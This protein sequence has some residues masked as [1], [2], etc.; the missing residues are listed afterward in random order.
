MIDI[1]KLQE[2][3]CNFTVLFV[4]DDATL[5]SKTIP[6]FERFFKKVDAASDGQKGLDAYL[7]HKDETNSYYDIVISDIQMPRMDGI[8]LSKKILKINSRQKIII[9]SAHN[10]TKYMVELINI[11]IS[12][13][14]QKPIDNQNMFQVM[15]DVS[16]SLLGESTIQ[17]DPV[18][19]FDFIRKALCKEEKIIDLSIQ[20]EKLL[21]L[22]CKN[23]NQSFKPVDIFNHIYYDQAEK[24]FSNDSV[25]SLIKRLRKKLPENLI[26][27]TPGSGYSIRVL[28]KSF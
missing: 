12:G 28:T 11:G 9:T 17:F 2:L 24:E 6:V 19:S 4:E 23:P 14:F 1:K 16:S 25:K 8:E 5:R 21:E 7:A 15:H 3:T 18:Y 22:L 10:D 13:F 27:N 26:I 20:E